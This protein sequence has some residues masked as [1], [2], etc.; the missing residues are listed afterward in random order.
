MRE[1]G[2]NLFLIAILATLSVARLFGF[3]EE[4]PAALA[5]WAGPGE[6]FHIEGDILR[7]QAETNLRQKAEVTTSRYWPSGRIPY[8]FDESLTDAGFQGRIEDAMRLWE[9]G[10]TVRFVPREGQAN[11]VR[12]V[13]LPGM[14]FTGFAELG[15]IGGEQFVFL[16][17]EFV[18][19]ADIVH[20]LGHVLGFEHEHQRGDRDGFI[21]VLW[22]NL[23]ITDRG[24]FAAKTWYLQDTPY[25]FASIMHYQEHLFSRNNLSVLLPHPQF[26]AFRNL[27]GRTI[28][29]LD[30]EDVNRLYKPLQAGT[31]L[32]IPDPN[33]K[34]L[35]VKGF[36]FNGDGEVDS[37]EAKAGYVIDL[38]ENG[39][40]DLRGLEGFVN[41]WRLSLDQNEIEDLGPLAGLPSLHSLI[42]W[43]NKIRDLTPLAGASKLTQLWAV[44]NQI[45]DL[46]P[47]AELRDLQLLDLSHNRIS[48][49]SP[50]RGLRNLQWLRI[51]GNQVRDLAPLSALPYLRRLHLAHNRVEDLSPLVENI[52]FGN[53]LGLPNLLGIIPDDLILV[54]N[55]LQEDACEALATLESRRMSSIKATEQNHKILS[56]GEGVGS[57]WIPH[58]TRLD[59]G[60]TTDLVLVNAAETAETLTLTAFGQRGNSYQPVTFT[61]QPGE[62]RQ[63]APAE[64]GPA[65]SHLTIEG[66]E[67][68]RVSAV[69]RALTPQ[70]A[71]A[72]VRETS[73]IRHDFT[74]HPGDWDLVFDGMAAVNL[75]DLPAEI[76]AVMYDAAGRRIAVKRVEGGLNPGAKL[77]AVFDELFERPEGRIEIHSTEPLA[78]VFLRGSLAGVAPAW[79][80][81]TADETSLPG[82]ET[83]Y[84]SHVTAF[85]G[86]FETR[87]HVVNPRG[88]GG[89]VRLQPYTQE[90]S[91]LEAVEL[92]LEP[93]ESVS[94]IAAELLG[95]ETSHFTV[96]G[97]HYLEVSAIYRGRGSSPG[98]PAS[99]LETDRTGRSFT[100]FQG[101]WDQVWDGSAMVNIGD[102]PARIEAVRVDEMG[103][104]VSL[105]TIHEALRPMAK[106]LAVFSDFFDDDP[107]SRIIIRSDQP[108]STVFLRGSREGSPGY[109]YETASASLLP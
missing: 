65:P 72:H 70:A 49:I 47:L 23:R 100:L 18:P 8:I 97:D 48:D 85:E 90:G 108:L 80:F 50:L 66:S 28:S 60:F 34:A 21:R 26:S 15:M 99:V 101:E 106:A 43:N 89:M 30:I 69:Y 10:T 20:E 102:G 67:A 9:A 51:T 93:E 11:Y 41:L 39:I 94:A 6:T 61:L 68:V 3:E 83:R 103:R 13:Q 64:L 36:D 88:F 54:G 58:L 75:G 1:Q 44:Y 77:L 87:I 84:L 104:E 35:L 29:T 45:E 91:P 79:L 62:A 53:T 59:G 95:T 37:E 82:V 74:L 2:L 46:A 92:A 27:G 78:L 33:L 55:D 38:E 109:L 105:E 24:A 56:C 42:I 86:G 98:S 52:Q 71:S 14:R 25:D 19:R 4:L 17:N 107:G 73:H 96:D 12:I 81:Q 22:E 5:G 40:R 7:R 32:E 31:P 57:R 76:F 63:V 16:R